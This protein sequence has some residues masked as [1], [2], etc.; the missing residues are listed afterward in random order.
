METKETNKNSVKEYF[1]KVFNGMALGLFSSLIIGLIIKQI[2][3]LFKI[4][5]IVEFGQF[6]QYMMGPAIGAGVAYSLG[7]SPLGIFASVVTGAIGA[8]TIYFDGGN[9]MIKIGE[10]VGAFVA[11][12]IGAEFSKL[13]QGKT[14]VDIVLVPLGT[15]IVGGL[16]GH[17]IAPAVSG[18]M[19]FIGNMINLAT[20]LKPIPMGILVSVLMGIALT[21]P[22]SSAAIAISLGL[23]GLAAGAST[24]GCA[25]HMIG[26]A[27]AS[28]R[29]NGFGGFIAQGIGTSMLQIPNT[30]RNPKIWIPAVA[31]SA[32]LGPISTTIFKMEGNPIGAGM[33]TSGLVGQF[34]TIDTMGSSPRV[35]IYILLLHFIL[36]GIISFIVSE[37]MRKKGCIKEGDMKI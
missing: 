17:Y 10:P 24:V 12:L 23:S 32:I 19:A 30:I 29:D 6:A 34:A 14:K 20:E 16:V 4:Q 13:V 37:W 8:G 35:F 1:I 33:G 22:I 27:I 36:P 26:F 21:L 7:A 3:T 18:L 9:A 5:V 11:S 25:A 2:G 15:I 31:T 28:Y